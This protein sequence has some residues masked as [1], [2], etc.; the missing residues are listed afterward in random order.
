MLAASIVYIALREVAVYLVLDYHLNGLWAA[1]TKL[2]I[3]MKSSTITQKM[4]Y[5]SKLISYAQDL[6]DYNVHLRK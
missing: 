3:E 6:Y 2:E 4:S 1:I 5:A